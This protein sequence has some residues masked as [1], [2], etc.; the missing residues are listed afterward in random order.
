M[1]YFHHSVY[2]LKNRKNT[3]P[4]RELRILCESPLVGQ[5][6]SGLEGGVDGTGIGLAP[7]LLHHLA[8]KPGGE[9]GLGLHLF[10]LVG[11]GGDHRLDGRID[12][13]GVGH[14]PQIA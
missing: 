2:G 14:L 12:G 4:V 7:R 13:A 5:I 1:G 3:R 10:H 11:V 6:E 9:L 8:D